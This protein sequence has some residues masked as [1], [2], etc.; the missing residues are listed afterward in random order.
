MEA[1]FS[2]LEGV[3]AVRSGYCGGKLA[4]PD[5]RTVC[6]GATGHAEAVEVEFDASTLPYATLLEV[7]FA[8]HDPTTPNRQGHDIGTQYRSAIF[9]LSDAQRDAAREFIAQS[10]ADFAAPIVTEVTPA[11][12]FYPAEVEHH[13]YYQ[14]HQQAPYCQLTIAPKLE[15]LHL[16]FKSIIKP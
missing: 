7:F 3:S 9:Y 14:E 10:A 16:R 11:T 12:T 2:R 4:N 8:S 13:R 6:A 15:K 1:L 5:Y